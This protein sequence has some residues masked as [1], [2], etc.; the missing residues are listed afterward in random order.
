MSLYQIPTR[1]AFT[2]WLTARQTRRVGYQ[3]RTGACPLANWLRQVNKNRRLHVCLGGQGR[4]LL[5]DPDEPTG[6]F[7]PMPEWCADFVD[8]FDTVMEHGPATGADALFILTEYNDW[9]PAP[10]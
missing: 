2:A 1:D 5:V 10:P 8:A 7:D 9:R 3:G 4:V 6:T